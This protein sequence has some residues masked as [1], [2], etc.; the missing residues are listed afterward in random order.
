MTPPTKYVKYEQAK[1]KWNLPAKG[2]WSYVAFLEVYGKSINELNDN[3][4]HYIENNKLI[5]E[6]ELENQ[7]FSDDKRRKFD[8]PRFSIHHY[9]NS[10]PSWINDKKRWKQRFTVIIS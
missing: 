7:K 1:G 5:E 3:I 8:P 9:D 4:Q 2:N 6:Y 10:N